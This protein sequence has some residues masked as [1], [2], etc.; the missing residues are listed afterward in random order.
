MTH[1][2]QPLS[3]LEAWVLQ[4]TSPRPGY[5]APPGSVSSYT[6]NPLRAQRFA[7]REEAEAQACIESERAVRLTDLF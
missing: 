6:T 3:L 4:R 7:T 1:P 2:Y 5:V